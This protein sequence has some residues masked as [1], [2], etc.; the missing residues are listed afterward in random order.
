MNESLD[1]VV[2]DLTKTVIGEAKQVQ[3]DDPCRHALQ[4]VHRVELNKRG[5]ILHAFVGKR[6]A[7][8]EGPSELVQRMKN[9]PAGGFLAQRFVAEVLGFMFEL[10]DQVHAFAGLQQRHQL[11]LYRRRHRLAEHIRDPAPFA[12]CNPADEI[13]Q[14]PIP[15]SHNALIFQILQGFAQDRDR[16]CRKHGDAPRFELQ[17]LFCCVERIDMIDPGEVAQRSNS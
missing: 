3:A 9:L 1:Q 12:G 11:L 16:L 6:S 4:L 2:V 7:C 17:L 10:A 5:V 13:L 8:E 14:E 15:R